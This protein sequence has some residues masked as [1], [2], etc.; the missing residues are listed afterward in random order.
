[1]QTLGWMLLATAASLLIVPFAWVQAAMHRWVCRNLRFSD[2]TTARFQGTGGQMVGWLVLYFIIVIGFQVINLR[3]TIHGVSSHILLLAGYISALA[4]TALVILRWSISNVEL[5]S[6]ERLTFRGSY[7][8]LMGWYVLTMVSVFSLI[9][10]AW[11]S[12][13]MYRW[14]A[15]NTR[16]DEVE[17]TF[18]GK[19]HE[20]LCGIVVFALLS[21]FIFPIPWMIVGVIQWMVECTT[22]TRIKA[23]LGTQN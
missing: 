20:M 14:I 11:V 13:A 9:G 19:G 12:A 21:I 16:G 7:M 18:H 2:G 1:M 5:S 15:R 4:G 6:G 23:P 22:L 8:E 17:F 3:I 10:W